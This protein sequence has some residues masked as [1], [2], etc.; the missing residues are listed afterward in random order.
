VSGPEGE[1]PPGAVRAGR[2]IL[3]RAPL[4]VVLAILAWLYLGDRPREITLAYDLPDDPAP[5]RVEVLLRGPDGTTAAALAWGSATR[6]AED[7][8]EQEALLAP[9]SY[10][11]EASLAYADGTTREVTRSLEITRDDRRIVVHLKPR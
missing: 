2:Q 3:R 1:R 4:L 10:R 8:R 9:G 7:G 5:A 11:L 6:P